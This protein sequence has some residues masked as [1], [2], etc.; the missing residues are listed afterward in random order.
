MMWLRGILLASLIGTSFVSTEV[1]AKGPIVGEDPFPLMCAD[2]SGEWRSDSGSRFTIQQHDC[3]WLKFQFFYG[4]NSDSVTI[5]PDNRVRPG[6]GRGGL[7]RHRWNSQN[8]ATVIESHRTYLLD[9]YR[10]TIVTMFERA[11]RGLLL[12]T[13]YRTIEFL[14]DSGQV[15]HEF[16]QEVFRKANAQSDDEVK[17]PKR[18]KTKNF[19]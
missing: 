15:R 6:P 18:G 7:I 1:Q 11:T 10:I 19:R 4:S 16:H 9:D 12:Q 17:A 3:A 13:T 5:V 8:K 14:D 2:F